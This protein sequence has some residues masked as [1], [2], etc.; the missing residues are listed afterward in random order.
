MWVLSGSTYFEFVYDLG[1]CDSESD[2]LGE[3]AESIG[4]DGIAV[5]AQDESEGEVEWAFFIGW[6]FTAE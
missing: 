2:I 5:W 1:F 4:Y 3:C 6:A